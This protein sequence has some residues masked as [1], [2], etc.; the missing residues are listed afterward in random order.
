MS[1]LVENKQQGESITEDETH[2]K[3]LPQSREPVAPPGLD[4]EGL[5]RAPKDETTRN[6][7]AISAA[8]LPLL[9]SNQDSPDP[10]G[11]L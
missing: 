2:K 9:G 11:P 5:T 4:P 1:S 3:G 7:A 8:V 6:T 10:E